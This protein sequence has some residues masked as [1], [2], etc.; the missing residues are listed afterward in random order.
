MRQPMRFTNAF[1]TIGV[2]DRLLFPNEPTV[3]HDLSRSDTLPWITD[4]VRVD[5]ID[6]DEYDFIT[7]VQHLQVNSECP[8]IAEANELTLT[9]ETENIVFSDVGTGICHIGRG[10]G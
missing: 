4:Y 10:Q 8:T 6:K 9:F 7:M 3:T 5:R 2:K 1:S